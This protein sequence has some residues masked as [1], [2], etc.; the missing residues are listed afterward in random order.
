MG[1]PLGCGAPISVREL[2]EELTRTQHRDRR[3]GEVGQMRVAGHDQIRAARDRERDE[4][5]VVGIRRDGGRILEV[6]DN[7]SL[8]TES[9]DICTRVGLVDQCAELRAEQ[10]L[11]ELVEQVGRDDE[12]EFGVAPAVNDLRWR[13]RRG[14]HSRDEHAR[15]EDDPQHVLRRCR[16][17][18]LAS[19]SVY[20]FVRE[21]LRLLRV[22]IAAAADAV[23]D[24]ETEVLTKR[25]LNDVGVTSARARSANS[26]R[27]KDVGIKVHGCFGARHFRT[28]ES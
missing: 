13:S 5:V 8:S 26:R 3:I 12:I 9:L 7:Q 28:I 18:P 23:D 16:N 10:D 14:Q 11:E 20:G 19:S 22:K 6:V 25:V 2:V 17:T 4:I 1:A 27:T 21:P 15:V 24:G